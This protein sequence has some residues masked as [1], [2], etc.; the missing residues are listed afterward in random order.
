MLRVLRV[1]N[2]ALMDELTVEFDPGLTVITGETGAGKSMIVEAIAAL[3]GE[4]IEDIS[5]RTGKEFAEITGI[6]EPSQEIKGRL[7]EMG[8]NVEE[9]LIIRRRLERGKKQISYFNDQI[10]SVNLLKEITRYMVDL[11]GQ[12]ENQ[13]LFQP[14]NHLEL[15]DRYADLQESCA[16]Y[17]KNFF[18]YLN[19]KKKINEL[20]NTLREKN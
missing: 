15:L 12:Y 1:K 11:V 6:F 8:I 2:F 20:Q 16:E 10:V 4:R 9:E 19:L 17:K 18:E 14:H 5:I 13:S 7:A 3:C